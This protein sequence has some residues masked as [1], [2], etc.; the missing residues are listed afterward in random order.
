MNRT[1]D[2]L[3]LK[4][5]TYFKHPAEDIRQAKP[6][7]PGRLYTNFGYICKAV[8]LT[9]RERLF[10]KQTENVGALPVEL[11][12]DISPS[13]DMVRQIS[14]LNMLA[15]IPHTDLPSRCNFCDFHRRGLPC[16][17]YNQ[18]KDGSVVCDTHKYI[19]LKDQ[20]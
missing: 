15:N 9:Q 8:P 18:L 1:L 19:I 6:I 17:F 5:R 14:Q 11:L 10:L 16:P 3:W 12:R 7:I 13:Q 20:Q 2:L 4:V